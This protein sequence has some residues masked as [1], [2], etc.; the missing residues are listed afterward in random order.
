[1][2]VESPL[3]TGFMVVVEV[4]GNPRKHPSTSVQTQGHVCSL[5]KFEQG[6]LRSVEQVWEST[7]QTH[8]E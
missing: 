7:S 4:V 5:K 1:L 3:L 2:T 6:I 8:R